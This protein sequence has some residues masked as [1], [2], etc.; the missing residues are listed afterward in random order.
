MNKGE[1]NYELSNSRVGV[2]DITT[3]DVEGQMEGAVLVGPK[4]IHAFTSNDRRWVISDISDFNLLLSCVIY[5][6][7]GMK[8]ALAHAEH[9]LVEKGGWI[10][11]N[12]GD[13]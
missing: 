13:G 1:F 12:R 9:Q 7:A 8:N 5:R 11:E 6:L 4:H 3:V 10:G 2:F